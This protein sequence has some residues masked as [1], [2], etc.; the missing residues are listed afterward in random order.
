MQNTS[1]QVCFFGT[2][3]QSYSSNKI[4]LDGLKQNNVT[5]VEVHNNIPITKLSGDED[6][7]I[8]SLIKRVLNKFSLIELVFKQRKQIASSDILFVGYP[9]HFDFIFG[10][11]VAKV[12]KL[13]LVFYPLIIL[14]ITFTDDVRVL[15]KNSWQAKILKWFEGW[16]YRLPDMLVSDIPF[17]KPLFKKLFGISID[18]I[19]E[20][21]IGADDRIYPYFPPKKDKVLNVTYYGLYSPLHGVKHIIECAR[22]LKNNKSIK[23]FM[24]GKGQTY[25]EYFD[26]AQSL[27][28]KNIHFLPDVTEKEA[29]P[30]I[31][32]ADI[33]LGFLQDSPSVDRVLPNKVYQ[34]LALGK[35]VLTADSSASRKVFQDMENIV[36]VPAADPKKL[37]EKLVYLSKYPNKRMA[38]AQKG[39]E[40][41][42]AR[43]TPKAIGKMLV[44]IFQETLN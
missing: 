40:L 30:Y 16:L 42:K 29:R 2:Y 13:K 26:Q 35:T 3:D 18:K 32:E 33:F 25:Q 5:V 38:I 1:P 20:I 11:L 7:V 24:I 37:A 6:L 23:F 21:P 39:Y 8:F 34:G 44:D 12:F 28:L 14:Y 17:Q 36:L 19:R 43:F 9:G 15:D 27:G 41:Y 10:F 31:K 4:I 22:L